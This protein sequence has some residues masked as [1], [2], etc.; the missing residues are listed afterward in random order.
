MERLS[1]GPGATFPSR[2]LATPS[3]ARAIEGRKAQDRN[4]DAMMDREGIRR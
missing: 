3:P 4:D 1:I 2:R